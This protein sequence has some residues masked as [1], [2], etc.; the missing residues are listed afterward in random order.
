[1]KNLGKHE[2]VCEECQAVYDLRKNYGCAACVQKWA[3]AKGMS[4]NLFMAKQYRKSLR[5]AARKRKEAI[6]A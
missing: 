3:G 5:D 4:L 2:W 6:T 1:M